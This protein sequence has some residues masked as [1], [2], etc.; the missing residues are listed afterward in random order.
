LPDIHHALAIDAFSLHGLDADVSCL[1]TRSSGVLCAC[2]TA[3]YWPS[4][5]EETG[6][7]DGFVSRASALSLVVGRREKVLS[8]VRAGPA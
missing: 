6:P 3:S 4:L 1:P 5:Q 7:S 2:T 8:T